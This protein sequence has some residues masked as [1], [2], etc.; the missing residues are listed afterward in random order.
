MSTVLWLRLESDPDDFLP[1][2]LY[3]LYDNL[4]EMDRHCQAAGIRLLSEFVDLSEMGLDVEAASDAGTGADVEDA[5]GE[6]SVEWVSPGELLECLNA[7]RDDLNGDES[8]DQVLEEIASV[9]ERCKEAIQ[10]KGR[11]RLLAVM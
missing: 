4:E 8:Q 5:W 11:V 3:E 6:S 10:N 1:E 9:I 2:D 7:L